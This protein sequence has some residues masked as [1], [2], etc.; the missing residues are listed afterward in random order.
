MRRRPAVVVLVAA[1][2]MACKGAGAVSQPSASSVLGESWSAYVRRF[3]QE[4]GRVIDHKGGGISTSE[5]QAYAM[6]RAALM[7]DR[8]VFDKTYAWARNNLNARI[9]NDRL[10]AWKWGKSPSGD[11]QVL[12]RAFA[13][14]A[15]QDAA[16]ALVMAH[17]TWGDDRYLQDARATLAD[18]WR[19]GT[20]EVN[21]RRFL[22][23]GD[24][25]CTRAECRLN[26]S[27]A[28]P[29][30]YRVFDRVDPQRGW[31][32]LVDT[33]YEL[34]DTASGFAE[35]RLPPD[36]IVLDRRTGRL[37]RGTATD[38]V[39]S[40]DAFRVL[41]RIAV[42]RDLYDEPRA[43]RY[44]R[45]TLP[46]LTRRWKASRTIPAVIA[47]DG[48]AQV[49]YESLEMLASLMAA[50]QS[51]EPELARAVHSRLQDTYAGGIWGDE[52][53]YYIQNWAWFGTAAYERRLD[54][55]RATR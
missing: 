1:L 48:T 21:G 22:L 23:A 38:N 26:P 39:F 46:W 27:Y 17:R 5:G 12:D 37:R 29:Y 47:P 18:L 49:R 32:S 30:A 13:S 53:S 55:L 40:Y 8:A 14:D 41:W 6:L 7:R 51:P 28:A 44:L 34:L 50:W 10:W 15:D 25:L 31:L 43:H 35:T 9:R 45:N 33:S 24:T 19:L 42:D 3:I 54:P 36:W 4:D 52:T 2:V 16:L 11:W 20:I